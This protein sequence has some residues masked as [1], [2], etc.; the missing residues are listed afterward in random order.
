MCNAS[1]ENRPTSSDTPIRCP[2]WCVEHGEF[3]KGTPDHSITHYGEEREAAGCWVR[4]VRTDLLRTGVT[5]E[6][7]VTLGQE[8]VSLAAVAELAEFLNRALVDA[9]LSNEVVVRVLDLPEGQDFV[10][11]SDVN[12][13]AVA[14]RLDAAGRR[15]ALAEAGVR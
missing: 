1:E 5:G 10:I 3:D 12:V 4:L 6:V 9:L 14:R 11:F 13:V 15:R 2:S 7:E 8:P